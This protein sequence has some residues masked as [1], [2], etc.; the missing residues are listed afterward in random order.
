MNVA[1]VENEC[2]FLGMQPHVDR[3][4]TC[5]DVPACVQQLDIL[6]AVMRQ[7]GD[8]RAR[9]HAQLRKCRGQAR[10]ALGQLLITE[11][12]AVALDH[13]DRARHTP[14]GAKQSM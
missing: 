8:A 10:R 5:A 9:S 4:G 1:V 13:G 3:N 12:Q 7:Q 14:G 2:N 11:L 6:R